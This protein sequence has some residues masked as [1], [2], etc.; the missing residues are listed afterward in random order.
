MG[1]VHGGEAHL[2]DEQQLAL[3]HGRP[4]SGIPAPG[5]AAFH[6]KVR[7]MALVADSLF[8]PRE[9]GMVLYSLGEADKIFSSGRMATVIP[10][11]RTEN[12]N[13]QIRS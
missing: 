1:V 3:L 13:N 4:D 8:M 5:R 11:A 6:T 2:L 7:Q 12:V 9:G 10:G